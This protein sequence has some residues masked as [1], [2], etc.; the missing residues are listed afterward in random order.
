MSR[1]SEIM[2]TITSFYYELSVPSRADYI[3]NLIDSIN[4]CIIAEYD[5]SNGILISHCMICCFGSVVLFSLDP[6]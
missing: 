5:G 6:K 4:E 1:C 2:T 3:M